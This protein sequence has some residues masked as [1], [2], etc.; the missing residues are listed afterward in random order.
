MVACAV[1][2]VD[3]KERTVLGQCASENF[4]NPLQRKS[5]MQ[6]IGENVRSMSVGEGEVLILETDQGFATSGEFPEENFFGEH[7]TDFLHQQPS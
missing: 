5:K 1:L 2:R 6:W 4:S 7:V 3:L